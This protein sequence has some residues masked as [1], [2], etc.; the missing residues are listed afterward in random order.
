MGRLWC[1]GD[2]RGRARRA[3]H[4]Q[5]DR[6]DHSGE[7]GDG[8]AAGNRQGIGGGGAPVLREQPGKRCYRGGSRGLDSS[9]AYLDISGNCAAANKKVNGSTPKTLNATQKSVVWVL[10]TISLSAARAKKKA[11]QR[12]VS[13]RHP[14]SVR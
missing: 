1:A 12:K 2:V 5:A 14:S 6:S 7:S 4:L 3:H 8:I 11:A 10:Q 9:T 13:L